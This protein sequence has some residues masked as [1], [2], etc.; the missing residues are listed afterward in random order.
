[1]HCSR[2]IAA[3]NKEIMPTM[4]FINLNI[5]IDGNLCPHQFL[6]V[7][8]DGINESICLGVPWMRTYN[9]IPEWSEN[10]LLYTH[11][12]NTY[13]TPFAKSD[14][15][16]QLIPKE[17]TTVRQESQKKALRQIWVQ[18]KV[19][20]NNPKQ[21]WIPKSKVSTTMTN[22][23]PTEAKTEWK[24]QPKKNHDN[25]IENNALY[26]EVQEKKL[27]LK[28][29]Q[30]SSF[31]G[32][33]DDVEK[34]AEVWIEAMDDYF[35][36]AK[37]TP[38]NQSM[39]GVAEDSQS[40]RE[41]KQAIKEMYLPLAHE[42]LKMNKFFALKQQGLSLE[43]YYSKFISLRRYAL[44]MTIEQ[45]K[46]RANQAQE[47]IVNLKTALELV[48][49]ERDSSARENEN[50]L[51]DLIDLQ[52]QLT[53]K[54]AQNH[55]LIKN[56]KKMKEQLKYEDAR[57]QK[58]IAFYNI[59]KNTLTVLLQNQEPTATTPS[60]S[61]SVAANTLAALQEELQTKEL[62]RQ[63]LISGFMSQTAQHEAKVKQLEEELARAKAELE[64]VGSLTSTSHIHQ[65]ETHVPIQPPQMLELPEFQGTKEEEQL[66]PAQGALD[67]REQMEQE[68]E[69]MPEG[70]AKEYLMYKKKVMESATLAFLQPEE[71]VKDFGN[72]FLPLPLMRHE[73]IL[74]KE[75]MRPAVP[76]N[77][78]GG[79]EGITLISE[80]AK[81][82]IED[83]PKWRKKW[84]S[85]R[86]RDLTNFHNM[87]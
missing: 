11:N 12:S 26:T 59:I 21:I 35:I 43:E 81:T 8:D 46:T 52:S 6:V 36:A 28:Q 50:F 78:D 49:K 62:Q 30:P 76:M 56:K 77:K 4:G 61:D 64:V 84:L 22:K 51:R 29:M 54:E 80:Q 16:W 14:K 27:L 25:N 53:R 47:E 2:N 31:R 63:L 67:I 41:I 40:W 18:K 83:H 66:R 5:N 82:H 86:P 60:T 75:K 73:A 33:G 79:Y 23:R 32:E 37:I 10:A 65:A 19:M 15:Q 17:Q 39:L 24:W 9:A 69:D 38:A 1:M 44:A 45:Q 71:Q 42:A 34:K 57:F 85:E 58:L 7:V 87:P 72:D 55:E 74:W 70:P 3:D 48:T 20:E 68:I 13:R